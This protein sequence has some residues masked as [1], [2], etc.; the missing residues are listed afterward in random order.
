MVAGPYTSCRLSCQLL[1]TSDEVT[2]V[3]CDET[4]GT[5]VSGKI[6]DPGQSERDN[7]EFFEAVLWTSRTG[8]PWRDLPDEFG[9]WNSVF[10]RFRR[11]VLK[12]VF[13]NVFQE[14]NQ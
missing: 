11:W 10:R 13:E 9:L 14:R 12:G 2:G 5:K 3:R 1:A 6:N 4:V 7:R 8:A